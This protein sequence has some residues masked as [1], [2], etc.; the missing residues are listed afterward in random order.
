MAL[1]KEDRIA[2]SKKISA[3]PVEIASVERSKAAVLKEQQKDIDVDNAHKRLVDAKTALIN[4]YQSEISLL[5]SNVRTT[6]LESDIIDAANF[7]STNVLYPRDPQN[8]APSLAPSIWTKTK[9]YTRNKIVGKTFA[10]VF[11]G[12]TTKESD[13][14]SAINSTL[15]SLSSYALIEQVSGQSCSNGTCSLPQYTD[16]TTCTTNGGVWTP[17]SDVISNNPTI[18]TLMT[19]LISQVNTWKTFLQNELSVIITTDTD[20]TRSSQNTAAIAQ[21]NTT[22]SGINTWLAY[23]SFNTAHGRTTCSSFYAYN[24]ALLGATKLQTGQLATFNSA[25]STRTS[26]ISTRISQLN[27][28]LGSVVQDLSTGD[29]TG[30]GLYFERAK[31]LQLRLNILGGSLVKVKGS[32]R[33][34]AAQDEQ[35]ANINNASSSYNLLLINSNLVAP[36]NGTKNL[37]VK[38]STGLSVGDIVY[39]VSDTQ[40]E[41]TLN[42]ESIS[43]NTVVVGKAIPAK[44]RQDE[45]ARLYKDIS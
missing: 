21:I 24:A 33:A 23:S 42:I 13:N 5:D 28:N 2:F 12:T 37:H 44:Y 7:T 32:D 19:T 29:I 1:T 20:A 22:I 38:S 17:S 39:L 14:I 35:I 26:F 18:Q 4:G 41:I 11:A 10:E 36:S 6:L 34:L 9:P 31:F 30:S 43:G 45:F 15:A 25:I 16:A 3:T 27:T 8:L 40:E